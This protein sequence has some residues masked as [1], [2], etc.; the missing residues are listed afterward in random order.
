MSGNF[1]VREGL[2]LLAGLENGS[3][4]SADAYTIAEQRDPVLLYFILRYLR[5]KYPAGKPSS[6]GVLQRVVELTS[7]Y[8][9]IVKKAKVGEHDSM[10]E[11]FDDAYAM[12]DYFDR[13]EELVEMIVDKLES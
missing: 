8:D 3:L 4:T 10:R 11:W 1:E 2:R 6:Q 5:E 13:S 7:T 12:R 9:D